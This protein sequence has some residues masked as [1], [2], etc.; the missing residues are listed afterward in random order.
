MGGTQRLAERAGSGRARQ[1]VM[2]GD[3]FGAEEL[4]RWNV[5]NYVYDDE[6][7]DERARAPSPPTSPPARPRPTR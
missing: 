7:F 3:L 2:T 4:E 1:L 5:V 6:G